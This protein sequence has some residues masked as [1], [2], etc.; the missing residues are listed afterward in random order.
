MELLL[1]VLVIPLIPFYFVSTVLSMWI[2]CLGIP[3]VICYGVFAFLYGLVQA[4][5][6]RKVV[7]AIQGWRKKLL[8][9][10]RTGR[11]RDD[12]SDSGGFVS[13]RNSRNS[14]SNNLDI[15]ASAQRGG[16]RA[17]AG[18][19][20]PVLST[21]T[22]I[23]NTS[24]QHVQGINAVALF[25]VQAVD[26]VLTFLYSFLVNNP[27]E[28]ELEHSPVLQ[29]DLD[30]QHDGQF[31]FLEQ[32]ANEAEAAQSPTHILF[33]E[34]VAQVDAVGGDMNMPAISSREVFEEMAQTRSYASPPSP[35]LFETVVPGSEL[36]DEDYSRDGHSVLTDMLFEDL[37][38]ALSID[39]TVR[40]KPASLYSV[41]SVYRSTLDDLADA[42]E[43]AEA[44]AVAAATSN[45]SHSSQRRRSKPPRS[46]NPHQPLTFFEEIA[47]SI[48]RESVSAHSKRAE[49]SFS[50]HSSSLR[51]TQRGNMKPLLRTIST[52]PHHH[53]PPPPR[54]RL[55]VVEASHHHTIGPQDSASQCGYSERSLVSD[56]GGLGAVDFSHHPSDNGETTDAAKMLFMFG[57]ISQNRQTASPKKR[58][59][60]QIRNS[61]SP[62]KRTNGSYFIPGL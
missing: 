44:A 56:E 57:A 11:W 22:A 6:S 62:Q 19:T 46:H 33:E 32:L 59:H 37:A 14:P 58:M 55:S 21:D 1:L 13:A 45:I 18:S 38:S 28:L 49:S 34:L 31:D 43:I 39:Q 51:R 4:I 10:Q 5:F 9:V 23:N 36:G 12:N 15:S 40:S 35:A 7:P 27:H 60:S 3:F 26:R 50:H 48:P 54:Q 20:S 30:T 52:D 42:S 41:P 24:L 2:F 29:Q 53:H 47:R 17:A 8:N 16:P 25:L 61:M